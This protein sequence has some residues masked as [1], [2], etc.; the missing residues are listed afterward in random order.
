MPHYDWNQI[1]AEQLNPLVTRK[2]IHAEAMTVAR[3]TI[4]KGAVVP[5]H[6]HVNEQVA[7]VEQGALKFNLDGQEILVSAGQAL[8]IPPDVPHGVEAMEDTVV[9]DLFT[10]RRQDWIDGDD[11][12][13]RK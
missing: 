3:L 11:S 5:A 1:P 12:Y 13:L 9:I 2:V 4:A 10:P 7:M 6:H 8:A